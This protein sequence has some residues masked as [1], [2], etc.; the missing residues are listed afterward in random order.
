ME[1]IFG[2]TKFLVRKILGLK[3]LSQ[4][5]LGPKNVASKK[6]FSQKC[7][8]QKNFGLRYLF[9]EKHFV[10]KKKLC[11]KYLEQKMLSLRPQSCVQKVWSL[12]GQ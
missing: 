6:M 3:N 5:I 7:G 1:N 8:V 4:Q 2:Y 12:L 10:A 11:Q 9:V